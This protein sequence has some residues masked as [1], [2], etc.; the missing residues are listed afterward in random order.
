MH[1]HISI[2]Y[3]TVRPP[4]IAVLVIWQPKFTLYLQKISGL[5]IF[6]LCSLALHNYFLGLT[7]YSI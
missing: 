1:A 4:I 6:S 5:K 7:K 3:A 2:K